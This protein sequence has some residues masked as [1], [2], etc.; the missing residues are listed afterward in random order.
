MLLETLWVKTKLKFS[1][2]RAGR[3]IPSI[4][5]STHG[6]TLVSVVVPAAIDCHGHPNLMLGRCTLSPIRCSAAE[7]TAS[8]TNATALRKMSPASASRAAHL[9]QRG[10]RRRR[11]AGIRSNRRDPV[12]SSPRWRRVGGS[13]SRATI[14]VSSGCPA[15]GPGSSGSL[16]SSARNRGAGTFPVLVVSMPSSSIKKRIIRLAFPDLRS[17]CD[18]GVTQAQDDGHRPERH[19]EPGARLVRRLLVNVGPAHLHVLRGQA[20]DRVRELH[21]RDAV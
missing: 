5:C 9:S 19:A 3:E 2:P 16:S 17:S 21:R 8:A 11:A 10:T 7:S 15:H 13:G 6:P 1:V 14:Q 12:P 18:R 4:F 20:L